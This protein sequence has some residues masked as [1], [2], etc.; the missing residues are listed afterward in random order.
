[1]VAEIRV[2]A[3]SLPLRPN[4]DH[5]P[6][7]R[8]RLGVLAEDTP[9]D[10]GRTLLHRGGHVGVGVEGQRDG[11]V[12]ELK[13]GTKATSDQSKAN[14]SPERAPVSS[15]A[16]YSGSSRSPAA[17]AQNLATLSGSRT[18]MSGFVAFGLRTFVAGLEGI[19]SRSTALLS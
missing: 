7:F 13:F 11:T 15:A 8:L 3:P 17:A 6:L 10:V 19:S 4:Y 12:P 16:M 2:A 14:N 18:C 5:S 1:M 9:H